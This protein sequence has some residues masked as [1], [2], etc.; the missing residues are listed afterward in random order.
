MRH[1]QKTL[2]YYFHYRNLQHQL[3]ITIYLYRILKQTKNG[4]I[5]NIT[6]MTRLKIT[7]EP[8]SVTKISSQSNWSKFE[9]EKMPFEQKYSTMKRIGN[10]RFTQ[11]VMGFNSQFSFEAQVDTKHSN[12]EDHETIG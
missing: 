2:S 6:D 5:R 10:E 4:L 8:F 3:F 1:I 9:K 7:M 12:N 11:K